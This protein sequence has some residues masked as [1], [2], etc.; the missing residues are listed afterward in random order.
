[1]SY[2]YMNDLP[3][4]QTASAEPTI[5]GTPVSQI[6]DVAALKSAA[7]AQ[8]QLAAAMQAQADGVGQSNPAWA[9]F[10]AQAVAAKG[11]ADALRQRIKALDDGGLFSNK[12]MIGLG[13][14]GLAVAGLGAA[15]YTG[16]IGGSQ[17]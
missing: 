10:N 6:T 7:A 9:N 1:M 5:N 3:S 12:L 2:I 11:F 14:A 15:W 4:N 13:V 8:D 16:H 17:H